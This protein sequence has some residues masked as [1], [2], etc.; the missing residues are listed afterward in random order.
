MAEN[1]TDDALNV[2]VDIVM[3]TQKRLRKHRRRANRYWMNI[4]EDWW[5][6]WCDRITYGDEG[7]E[8]DNAAIK[9]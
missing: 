3:D 4:T 8:Q 6:E 5:Y 2:V 7:G 9:A 1:L